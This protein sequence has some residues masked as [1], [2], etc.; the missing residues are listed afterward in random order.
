MIGLWNRARQGDLASKEKLLNTLLSHQSVDAFVQAWSLMTVT[1]VTEHYLSTEERQR[2]QGR[3]ERWKSSAVESAP[4]LQA[5]STPTLL[6]D[7]PS[8]VRGGLPSLGKRSR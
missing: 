5:P 7:S 4:R 6:K 1:S 8:V 3:R 2:L